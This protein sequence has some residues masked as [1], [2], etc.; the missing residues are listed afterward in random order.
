MMYVYYIPLCAILA[1]IILAYNDDVFMQGDA[2]V[3]GLFTVQ[4]FDGTSCN[5]VSMNSIQ[6]HEAVRW[7]FR[8]I[9]QRHYIQNVTLGE[10]RL[11]DNDL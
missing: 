8:E 10:S 4:N 1:Q 11:S 3:G 7:F 5:G 6:V 2:V 9:N